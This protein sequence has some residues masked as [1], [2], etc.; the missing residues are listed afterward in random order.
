M[1]SRDSNEI[2]DVFFKAGKQLDISVIFK[3]VYSIIVWYMNNN[4]GKRINHGVS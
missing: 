4:E 1:K 3:E 2:S